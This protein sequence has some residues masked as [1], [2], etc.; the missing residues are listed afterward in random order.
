MDLSILWR[1]LPA[2]AVAVAVTRAAGRPWQVPWGRA[3]DE[4]LRAGFVGLVIARLGWIAL[5]GPEVWRTMG[6][7]F[8]LLRAGVETWLGVAGASA[9]LAWGSRR[10]AEERAFL[11]TA[12]PAAALAGMATWH[13]T[14]GIEGVC[15]GLPV[16]WGVRLP[17]Y[18]SPAVPIGYVEGV[19]AGL[20]ALAA[21]RLRH[22]WAAAVGVG[23]A[24][25]L[26]RAGLAFGK[27]PL[28]GLPT[29]D[30]VLAAAVGVA[31]I[32]VAARLRGSTPP[33]PDDADDQ[34]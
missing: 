34:P 30:Q 21:W 12:G 19:V 10:D 11:L 28:V 16:P 4:V 6:A 2:I 3:L 33:R 20:L 5:A 23:G 24:Y 8:L 31:L 29:R 27:A 15:A 14:C 22:R 18:V 1:V 9:W 7:T 17:G 32:G 25:A 13:L 26:A